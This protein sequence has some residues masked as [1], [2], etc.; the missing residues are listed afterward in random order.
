MK[1]IDIVINFN[2]PQYIEDYVHRIGRTG[3][4]GVKGKAISFVTEEDVLIARDLVTI[5]ENSDQAIP[6]ELEDLC[7]LKATGKPKKQKFRETVETKQFK[8]SQSIQ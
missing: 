5:L 7:Y 6:K 3:R 8:A 2:M 4:A 1:D